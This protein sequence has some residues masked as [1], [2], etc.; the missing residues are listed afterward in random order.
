MRSSVWSKACLERLEKFADYLRS[1]YPE[2]LAIFGF[3]RYAEALKLDGWFFGNSRG[4]NDFDGC[5]TL[6]SFGTPQINLGA[7]SDRYLTLF[8]SLDGFEDYYRSLTQNEFI[9]LLGRMRTH[10]YPDEDFSFVTGGNGIRSSIKCRT[11]V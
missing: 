4:S 9:Q 1:Q 10:R 6:V 3:K 8:G 2:D 7:A 5:L 11:R